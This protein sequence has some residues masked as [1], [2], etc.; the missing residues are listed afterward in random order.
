MNHPPIVW[1]VAGSDSGAGAGLQADLRAFE[2]MDV[3]GCSVVAAITAQNS[4]G[5]Q[6]ISP[7]AP[8]VLDAQLAALAEDMP[9]AVIKVGMIG[10]VENLRVLVHWIDR[11][12]VHNPQLAVVVD[13]VLGATTGASFAPADLIQAYRD[14]LLPRADVITPN[15]AEAALLLQQTPLIDA[16]AIEHAAQSLVAFGCKTVTITGGDAQGLNSED[17]AIS[18]HTQGW[19]RLPRVAT[20]HNHGT[21][22]VFAASVAAAMARGFVSMEAL[23]LAKM[24]TTHALR[25]AYAAGQG[26]GPVRPRLDF[27]QHIENLPGFSLPSASRPPRLARFA[28]L[29]DPQL[30]LYA[31]VDSADW[32]QRV[33]AAGVRT[34]QL[35]IKKALAP[36]DGPLPLDAALRDEVRASIKYARAVNAQLFINDHWQLAIEE[37]AYGVHLGQEDLHI[38]DLDAIAQAGLRLGISTHCYWEVC[39]AWQLQPSYIACGPIHPTRAK[40]MPWIAQTHRNLAYWSALLPLPVVAIGGMTVARAQQAMQCG[41]SGVALISGICSADAPELAIAALRQAVLVDPRQERVTM[42]V[43][44]QATLS[45]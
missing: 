1:S 14:E 3:H 28:P 21:G 29:S 11:L 24:A 17:Y 26:A 16:L 2:A 31:V 39:R 5:V 37:G 32:V 4:M 8:S 35:R 45:A 36:G 22:C 30:G 25:H 19:L 15:R 20:E 40:D 38:A 13:P 43:L 23:V 27:A 41:A 42:P 9:P 7:V 18:P 33:L 10:S 6:L 44:P 12:R 34:V